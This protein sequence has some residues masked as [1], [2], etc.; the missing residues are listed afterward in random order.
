[1]MSN[2]LDEQVERELR[3]AILPAGM[4][5]EFS[6]HRIPG[7]GYFD[8]AGTINGVEF[9]YCR[10][11]NE[12]ILLSLTR[13]GDSLWMYSKKGVVQG[14][15]VNDRSYRN[16]NISECGEPREAWRG[17]SEHEYDAAAAVE[18]GK[19]KLDEVHGYLK[20]V[21]P[22]VVRIMEGYFSNTLISLED[23]ADTRSNAEIFDKFNLHP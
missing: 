1:M 9:D 20:A 5:V 4:D 16:P 19:K 6:G 8:I 22:G 21:A 18:L 13:D 2:K 17:L 3:R 23:R 15:Y 7:F 10:E 12:Q 14:I 11:H